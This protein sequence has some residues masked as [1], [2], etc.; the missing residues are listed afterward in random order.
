MKKVRLLLGVFCL[1][2]VSSCCCNSN[3][4]GAAEGC[5]AVCEKSEKKCCAPKCEM[6]EEQK[7]YFEKWQNFEN[8]AEE[9]QK[10]L[11][12]K[13]KACFEKEIADKKACIEKCE[14]MLVNFDSL[15]VA[16]QKELLD[17][18]VL[19]TGKGKC[20]KSKSKCTEKKECS[21]EKKDGNVENK[22]E[23]KE[24]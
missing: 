2:L 1:A 10:E 9:E 5:K 17:K 22:E 21:V 24:K 20:C 19:C 15:T 16:E 3:K 4:E 11:I 7:A 8:L 14:A 12:G 6:S 18:K 23:S 13:A